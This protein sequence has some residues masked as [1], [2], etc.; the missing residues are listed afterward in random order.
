MIKCYIY[1]KL[2]R[3]FLFCTNSSQ[4][5]IFAQ[6]RLKK[7]NKF[8]SSSWEINNVTLKVIE[9]RI[10]VRPVKRKR[11]FVKN[12]LEINVLTKI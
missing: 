12:Q 11:I 3:K 7:K 8:S 1:R 10:S 2:D 5:A 6:C 4:N 9:R